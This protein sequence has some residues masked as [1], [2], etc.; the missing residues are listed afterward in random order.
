M[1]KRLSG[2]CF[3]GHERD[4]QENPK[5]SERCKRSHDLPDNKSSGRHRGVVIHPKQG[6]RIQNLETHEECNEHTPQRGLP[7]QEPALPNHEEETDTAKSEDIQAEHRDAGCR[8]D[9]IIRRSHLLVSPG[10]RFGNLHELRQ[11]GQL[12]PANNEP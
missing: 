6:P 4:C 8:I 2:Q 11:F 10:E 7:P 1:R 9:G 5:S 12:I 3:S